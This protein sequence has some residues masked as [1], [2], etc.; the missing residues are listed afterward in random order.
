MIGPRAF[1][2]NMKENKAAMK[3]FLFVTAALL[4]GGALWWL[5]VRDGSSSEAAG[6]KVS[7]LPQLQT[8]DLATVSPDARA[9]AEQEASSGASRIT[10]FLQEKGGEVEA[11]T[12]VIVE[13]PPPD[14]VAPA[15]EAE[16]FT[17]TLLVDYSA[18]PEA[19]NDVLVLPEA[20]S[21][22]SDPTYAIQPEGSGSGG[23][24]GPVAVYANG[25]AGSPGGG[26]NQGG[27]AVLN[28]GRSMAPTN[29]RLRLKAREA[30]AMW[31][32]KADL[33]PLISGSVVCGSRGIRMQRRE[34]SLICCRGRTETTR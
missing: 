8:T 15:E 14:E 7:G 6:G 30:R 17:P 10:D 2:S 32:R 34:R 12:V 24:Y 1:L 18:E 13:E 33:F 20:D 21:Y 28:E 26:R 11:E 9:A 23:F 19:E 31:M 3:P 5:N 25:L 4:V 29:R 27:P 22:S 16:P